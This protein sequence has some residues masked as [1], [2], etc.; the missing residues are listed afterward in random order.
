MYST[1]PKFRPTDH[2]MW[3]TSSVHLLVTGRMHGVS[4]LHTFQNYLCVQ[5]KLVQSVYIQITQTTILEMH[6][7]T[8]RMSLV[9]KNPLPAIP[10]NNLPGRKNNDSSWHFIL[11]NESEGFWPIF[12]QWALGHSIQF[13]CP[14]MNDIV[15]SLFKILKISFFFL[16]ETVTLHNLFYLLFSFL[17]PYSSWLYRGAILPKCIVNVSLTQQIIRLNEWLPIA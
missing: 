4:A 9:C 8:S 1:D 17:A 13:S 3:N 16:W 14:V 5:I 2:M 11:Y 15:S 7:G 6:S 10:W 12:P